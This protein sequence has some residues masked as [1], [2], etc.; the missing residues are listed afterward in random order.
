MHLRA[1]LKSSVSALHTYSTILEV[2]KCGVVRET[3]DDI[4]HFPMSELIEP[5][6]I[7]QHFWKCGS[8]ECSVTNAGLY[9]PFPLTRNHCH[10][11]ISSTLLEEWTVT[12]CG[13]PVQPPTCQ[14]LIPGV[15][16]LCGRVE[17][18]VR[19]RPCT[20]GFYPGPRFSFLQKPMHC[21]F[22]FDLVCVHD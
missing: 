2:W 9:N 18:A 8:M 5:L 4:T 17:F 12:Y 15:D 3:T 10:S 22:K 19:F 13:I 20:K 1:K 11:L 21:K 6:A 7:L 14:G 16:A